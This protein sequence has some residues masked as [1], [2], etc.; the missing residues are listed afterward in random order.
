MPI[1]GDMLPP[2]LAAA[3]VTARVT[4]ARVGTAAARASRRAG[5]FATLNYRRRTSFTGLF[6]FQ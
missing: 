4:K 5:Q 1:A 6:Y 3:A 2:Q